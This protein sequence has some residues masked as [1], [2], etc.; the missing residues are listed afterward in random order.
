MPTRA[1]ANVCTHVSRQDSND[2]YELS[3]D[4]LDR[5]L[6][7]AVGMLWIGAHTAIRR[8]PA[9]LLKCSIVDI[10]STIVDAHV[11]RCAD[12]YA[13]R[14]RRHIV[15]VVD[16][17]DQLSFRL[18]PISAGVHLDLH[19]SRSPPRRSPTK[20]EAKIKE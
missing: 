7:H 16:G 4:E 12:L 3:P 18:W 13:P 5:A 9:Q 15:D 6:L 17:A 8:M 1:H 20:N 2:I 19:A 10:K 11:Q 14:R